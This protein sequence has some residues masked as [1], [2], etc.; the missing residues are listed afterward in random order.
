MSA[1]QNEIIGA[2]EDY[3]SSRKRQKQPLSTKKFKHGQ[4]SRDPNVNRI[5]RLMHFIMDSILDVF[6][7]L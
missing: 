5:I 3:S 7:L 4:S 6:W 1:K 2:T